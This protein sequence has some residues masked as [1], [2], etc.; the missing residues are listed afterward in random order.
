MKHETR[1]SCW[2]QLSNTPIIDK[3]ATICSHSLNKF[4]QAIEGWIENI[5]S[6]SYSTSEEN[7][8]H[9]INH[10][11]QTILKALKTI[12]NLYIIP[13]TSTH[14]KFYKSKSLRNKSYSGFGKFKIFEVSTK[15]VSNFQVP[16]TITKKTKTKPVYEQKRTEFYDDKIMNYLNRKNNKE[17]DE[18]I[19]EFKE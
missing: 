10:Q 6:L 15:S 19:E 13:S 12:E 16:K 14:T 3:I 7:L 1:L 2:K 17:C 5:Q 8:I 18:K 11:E 9:L 4:D